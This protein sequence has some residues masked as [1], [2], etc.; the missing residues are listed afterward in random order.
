MTK[1]TRN[2]AT[3]AIAFTECE[4]SRVN[5]LQA[6]CEAIAGIASGE[7]QATWA[8]GIKTLTVTDSRV[9]ATSKIFGLTPSV[10]APIGFW[11]ISSQTAGSFVITS[12]EVET[13]G[14]IATY[15]VLN[16]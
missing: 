5:N 15:G 6:V 1:I 10:N 16:Q 3:P 13:V 7:G 2:T 14:T 12:T 8:G 9:T 4:Q 11:Y